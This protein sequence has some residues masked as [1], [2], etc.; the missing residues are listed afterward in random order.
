MWLRKR[1]QLLPLIAGYLGLSASGIAYFAVF[2]NEALAWAVGGA[3]LCGLA[4]L[5]RE[6][7]STRRVR[8]LVDGDLGEQFTSDEVRKLRR[9]G[10]KVVDRVEFAYDDVD[11]VVVGPGGVFAIETKWTNWPWSVDAGRFTNPWASRAVRQASRNRHRIYHLL[12]GNFGLTLDVTP[13]LVVWGEG[14]PNLDEPVAIDGVVVLDGHLL[15]SYLTGL[16]ERLDPTSVGAARDAVQRFVDE[17]ES[18]TPA[19]ARQLT[20][21]TL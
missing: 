6:A 17:R 3:L 21:R 16:P 18:H 11:H 9:R 7:V 20:P 13:L 8:E 2:V 19:V 5:V 1:R 4:F 10:W 14:R 15:R 12:R